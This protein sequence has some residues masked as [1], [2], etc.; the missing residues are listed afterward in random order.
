MAKQYQCSICKRK[1]ASSES[2]WNHKQRC[3][4]VPSIR[5]IPTFD[6]SEF[7]PSKP[8]PSPKK[9]WIKSN[10]SLNLREKQLG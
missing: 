5:E 10:S 2:L 9:R 1:L 4:V 6:G 7:E 3:K 8:K